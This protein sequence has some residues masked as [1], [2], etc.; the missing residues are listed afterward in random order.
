MR[1]IY[2]ALSLLLL[3]SS[4]SKEEDNV[5]NDSFFQFANEEHPIVD[6]HIVLNY[7]YRANNGSMAYNY[8]LQLFMDDLK[9]LYESDGSLYQV[10]GK[11]WQLDLSFW[12][13][14]YPNFEG[15]N[16]KTTDL[17]TP[18]YSSWEPFMVGHFNVR[19]FEN[20]K[21]VEGWWGE[22]ASIHIAKENGQLRL[23]SDTMLFS[24]TESWDPEAYRHAILDY[25]APGK[26]NHIQF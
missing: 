5:D 3:L 2:F 4:C 9:P 21:M 11:G 18:S 17:F 16:Y 12:D 1:A 24:F 7:G 20:G 14:G 26:P 25:T 22:S 19:R 23:F 8:T 15:G 13:A 6:Y 10:R